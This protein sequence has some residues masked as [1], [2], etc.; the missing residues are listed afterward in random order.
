MS[1]QLLLVLM[2]ALLTASIAGL[3]SRRPFYYLPLYWLIGVC[4]MLIGQVFG[5]A[6]GITHF[7]VGEVEMGAGLA[8][9]AAMLIAMHYLGLWYTTRGR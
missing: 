6:A 4:A 3:I 5:K 2:V 1:P 9:N 7:M 8:V